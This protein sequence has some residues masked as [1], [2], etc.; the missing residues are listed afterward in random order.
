MRCH[1]PAPR[2]SWAVAEAVTPAQWSSCVGASATGHWE[3]AK[4]LS[5]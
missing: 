1:D 3:P 5:D 4:G 2:E